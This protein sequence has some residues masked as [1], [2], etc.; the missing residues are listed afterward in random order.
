M[1]EQ[2]IRTF[3]LGL[4]RIKGI[5]LAI[6]SQ[7]ESRQVMDTWKKERWERRITREKP[8]PTNRKY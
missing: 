8:K 3:G 4:Q 1:Q 6:S 2:N 5:N 7:Q